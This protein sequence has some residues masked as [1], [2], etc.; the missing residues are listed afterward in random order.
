MAEDIP[1]TTL[2]V[3]LVLT[4][5]ISIACTWVVLDKTMSTGIVYTTGPGQASGDVKVNIVGASEDV[6]PEVGQTGGEVKIKIGEEV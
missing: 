4:V 1:K 6:G 3:L 5:I 2:V